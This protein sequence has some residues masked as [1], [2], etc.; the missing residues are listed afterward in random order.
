[1]GMHGQCEHNI[2]RPDTER[3]WGAGSVASNYTGLIGGSAHSLGQGRTGN[4]GPGAGARATCHSCTADRFQQGK[5]TDEIKSDTHQAKLLMN[6][7]HGAR[8]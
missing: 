4:T 2:G 8:Q 1:M 3:G 6:S 5:H 7:S